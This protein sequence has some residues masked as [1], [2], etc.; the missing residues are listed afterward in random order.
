M[1]NYLW[2]E[3]H[4]KNVQIKSEYAISKKKSQRQDQTYT[5]FVITYFPYTVLFFYKE[6]NIA[7]KRG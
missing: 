6:V 7:K 4:R 3:Y 1:K 2:S 5:I